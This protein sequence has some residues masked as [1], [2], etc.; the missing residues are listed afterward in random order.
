MAL[1]AEN[2][3][4]NIKYNQTC[5]ETGTYPT[6]TQFYDALGGYAIALYVASAAVVVVLLIEFLILVRHFFYFVPSSRRVATLWVNS[7][8]LVVALATLFCV[9]LPQSSDFVWLFYRVYLGMA[10]GYFVDLTLAWYGGEADM[11][12]HVG[13]GRLVSFRVR[14]CCLCLV[15]PSATPFSKEKIH[16]LRGAVYQ[17]VKVAG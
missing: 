17:V 7:I 11:L 15:C 14:P 3:T 9:V 10:M 12:R 6:A 2:E 1:F 16:F 5:P 8:Y 4:E 13:E